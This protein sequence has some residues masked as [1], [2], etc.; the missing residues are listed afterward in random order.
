VRAGLP[1]F[2]G[3]QDLVLPR[4]TEP[5]QMAEPAA[6]YGIKQVVFDQEI[7]LTQ[8]I[9]LVQGRS[10]LISTVQQID[11]LHKLVQE[12]PLV[13][14]AVSPE[15]APTLSTLCHQAGLASTILFEDFPE[16]HHRE[17]ET[18]YQLRMERVEY[19]NQ[20]CSREGI[21]PTVLADREMRNSL[22]HIDRDLADSLTEREGVGWFIDVAVETR[23]DFD[24]HE[25][26][27]ELRFCRSYIIGEDT[28]LHLGQEMDLEKLRW[29]CVA[30]L[31][32]VFGVDYDD[33][34]QGS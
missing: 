31:A 4:Q 19:V 33:Q 22:T 24:T 27:D 29:Q 10:A 21:K 17:S 14:A 15:I 23:A 34:F 2:F 11:K 12:D 26:I 32:V 28:I 20:F 5:T 6:V 1:Q 30:V 25:D 18:A 3:I 9:I 13:N 8:N 16:P 7:S